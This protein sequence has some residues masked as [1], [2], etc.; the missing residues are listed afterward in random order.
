MNLK[1]IFIRF[2]CCFFLMAFCFIF[3]PLEV[4][5]TLQLIKSADGIEFFRSLESLRDV[6]YESWQL[7]VYPN[8]DKSKRVVLR[9]I[10]YPGRLRID[11]PTNLEV[12][13]GIRNW[14]LE[15]ITFLNK[16]L[17]H[18]PRTASAEFDM[19]PLLDDLSKN[20]PLR[21]FLQGVFF[22]LPI[23]PYLVSEWRTL[24]K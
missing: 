22:D 2:A 12:H 13:S 4:N 17:I 24:A 19:T 9:V 21:F 16:K 14:Y 11:H 6:D 3:N 7:V 10:G 1:G 8:P 15:D 23:P 18:D 5:A 20:R